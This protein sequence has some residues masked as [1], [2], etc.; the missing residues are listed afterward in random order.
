MGSDSNGVVVD[1]TGY[2]KQFAQG[3]T[4]GPATISW[5]DKGTNPTIG[6]IYMQMNS[7]N[8]STLQYGTWYN[9]SDKFMGVR[10][11]INGQRHYG[12]IRMS[13]DGY[14]ALTIKDWGY[15]P[16]PDSSIVA[17][18]GWILGVPTVETTNLA[19]IY[20]ANQSIVI[21]LNNSHKAYV[22]IYNSLGQKLIESP[23]L[24]GESPFTMMVDK[25]GLYV[26]YV[27]QDDK[28]S[29]RKLIIN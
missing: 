15:N 14:T 26:V 21:Q 23:E 6:L 9:M 8:N 2:P 1:S 25:P 16:I 19:N 27:E 24:F 7:L 4:I 22:A 18:A 29:V 13:V 20:V 11:V 3:D 28:M 10:F 5:Q 12:W 17:G